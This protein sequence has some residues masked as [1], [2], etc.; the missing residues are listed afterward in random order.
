MDNAV[1]SCDCLSSWRGRCRRC[2]L[3]LDCPLSSCLVCWATGRIA[4]TNLTRDK[5]PTKTSTHSIIKLSQESPQHSKYII[6]GLP[7]SRLRSS[8]RG[9]CN[10]Y[11]H[12]I[13]EYVHGECVWLGLYHMLRYN[14][15]TTSRVP[16]C[17]PGYMIAGIWC[18]DDECTQ[19]STV[20]EA[21]SLLR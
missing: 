3:T 13:Y 11:S 9:L 6:H 20:V 17:I 15:S 4:A 8:L 16:Y 12:F 10:T 14:I 18:S 5:E 7:N 2:A 21:R 19:Y 1:V